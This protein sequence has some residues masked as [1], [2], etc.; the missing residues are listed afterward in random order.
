MSSI[1]LRSSL[2]KAIKCILQSTD[3]QLPKTSVIKKLIHENRAISSEEFLSKLSNQIQ[4][5][6][7]DPLAM[8]L[9]LIDR[10]I[11]TKDQT[12]ALNI[13]EEIND[14]FSQN[15]FL[16]KNPCY[17][18]LYL[19]YL[20]FRGDLFWEF[21]IYHTAIHTYEEFL[22]L[23]EAKPITEL[24][25]TY[26]SILI[27]LSSQNIEEHDLQKSFYY[28][29]RAI[30]TANSLNSAL[31]S[32]MF[33]DLIGSLG[34]KVVKY[35]SYTSMVLIWEGYKNVA[36]DVAIKAIL[37]LS[38]IL[39]L[40]PEKINNKEIVD[41]INIILSVFRKKRNLNDADM[42]LIEILSVITKYTPEQ[43]VK[44]AAVLKKAIGILHKPHIH[45][46]LFLSSISGGPI[47]SQILD[48]KL[49]EQVSSSQEKNEDM[50]QI[51]L[52]ASYLYGGL[53]NALDS[54][55]EV[56]V[57]SRTDYKTIHY[58]NML[59]TIVKGEKT[60]GVVFTDRE[61]QTIT[62]NLIRYVNSWEEKFPEFDGVSFK[63][64]YRSYAKKM[65]YEL[66]SEFIPEEWAESTKLRLR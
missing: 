22:G 37:I 17:Y 9:I 30:K 23:Y 12:E 27:K 6:K 49:L 57:Q 25:D 36:Y 15:P 52:S 39:N 1:K 34:I 29:I 21:N 13:T 48:P 40:L 45:M 31:W 38:E 50:E 33:L 42:E 8:F 7:D 28:L 44:T 54:I 41:V 11:N 14:L 26:F 53:I 32:K 3:N 4:E 47:F 64:E 16:L 63:E 35:Y 46:F 59:L 20:V 51:S 66:F 19:E 18:S 5:T 65:Y 43:V 2:N 10:L 56:N 55:M 24:E 62:Y 61:S 60:I 58:S